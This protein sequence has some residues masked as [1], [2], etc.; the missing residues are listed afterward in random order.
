MRNSLGDKEIKLEA[1]ETYDIKVAQFT[2]N[3]NYTFIIIPVSE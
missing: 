2:Q 1:G 3:G